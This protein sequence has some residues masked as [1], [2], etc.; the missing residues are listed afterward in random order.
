M[1]YTVNIANASGPNCEIKI[2]F[3]Y[4][5]GAIFSN[6]IC[7]DRRVGWIKDLINNNLIQSLPAFSWLFHQ[8]NIYNFQTGVILKEK[9][10]R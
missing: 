1:L 10:V 4:T 8:K 6:L 2:D 3:K 5:P 7:S 9:F